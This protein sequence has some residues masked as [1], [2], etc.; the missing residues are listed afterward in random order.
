VYYIYLSQG[1]FVFIAIS[2]LSGLRTQKNYSAADSAR[3]PRKKDRI[4]AVTQR[5]LH[6][7][8]NDSW[9]WVPRHAHINIH[10]QNICSPCSICQT[11]TLI[12]TYSWQV[13]LQHAFSYHWGN[14]LAASSLA[15]PS[16]LRYLR[17]NR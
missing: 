10:G 13:Q 16:C 11:K 4:L 12:P 5:T 8:Q 15:S 3:E 1:G 2:S 6:L 17:F 14:T 7:G 9:E